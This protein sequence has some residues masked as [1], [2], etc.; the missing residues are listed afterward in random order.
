MVIAAIVVVRPTV[1]AAS[2]VVPLRCNI[3]LII[4]LLIVECK[5]GSVIDCR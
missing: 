1:V 2:V 3:V 5:R 4:K